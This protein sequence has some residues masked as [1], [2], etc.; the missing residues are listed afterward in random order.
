M[1]LFNV[2]IVFPLDGYQVLYI[3]LTSIYDETY[4]YEILKYISL[5]FILVI[6]LTAFIFKS[7]ALLVILIFLIK[8]YFEKKQFHQ[9]SKLKT[10]QKLANYFY[11]LKK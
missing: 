10:T 8:K 9:Y 11:L 3:I 1:I 6:F 5:F 7:L 2:M 4:T